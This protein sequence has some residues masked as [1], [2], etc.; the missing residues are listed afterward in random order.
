MAVRQADARC[1]ILTMLRLWDA[2]FG[3]EAARRADFLRAL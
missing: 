3:T 2:I 1:V